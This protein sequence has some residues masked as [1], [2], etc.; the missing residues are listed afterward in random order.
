MCGCVRKH[1]AYVKDVINPIA[2]LF[3][4]LNQIF[5][6]KRTP[7]QLVQSTINAFQRTNMTS[8]VSISYQ[9]VYNRQ[10]L[11]LLTFFNIRHKYV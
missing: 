4:N 2:I 11:F 3:H 8:Y 6:S 5:R 1:V 9:I 10:K 7:G